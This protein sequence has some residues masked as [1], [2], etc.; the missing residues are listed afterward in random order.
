MELENILQKIFREKMIS[1][2]LI[3]PRRQSYEIIEKVVQLIEEISEKQGKV[4]NISFVA[5]EEESVM[6]SARL[7]G[8]SYIKAEF[9]RVKGQIRYGEKISYGKKRAYIN[10]YALSDENE[11]Y[12]LQNEINPDLIIID[13]EF[14][15]KKIDGLIYK[16]IDIICENNSFI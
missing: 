12:R 5:T 3:Y 9:D 13:S 15:D 1:N 4:I 2:I 8:F 11:R 16:D 6:T 7:F 14:S 10:C